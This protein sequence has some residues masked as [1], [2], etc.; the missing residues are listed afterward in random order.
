MAEDW[1]FALHFQQ[2]AVAAIKDGWDVH[3]VCNVGQ[4]GDE[5]LS[6]IV[7]AGIHVIPVKLARTGITP[8]LDLK[9]FF[10]VY[11]LARALKPKIIHAVALKPILIS[12]CISSLAKIPLLAM[13]T[14]LG[15]VFTGESVKAALARPIVTTA[16]RFVTKNPLSKFV[17]LN[18]EDAAWIH[19]NFG[20]D[21]DKIITIPGTGIDLKRFSPAQQPLAAPFKIA[22]VG[23]MLKDKGIFEL[24]EAVKILRVKQIKLQLI[25]AG[26]PDPSNPAS[27]TE[28]QLQAW[29]QDGWCSCSGHIHEI[30][31]LYRQVHAVTLPSYREGLGMTILEAAATGLPCVATDVPGCRSAVVDGET[32]IL[33]PPR[34]PQ[35]LADAIERLALQP[36]LRQSMGA[37]ARNLV[38][39]KFARDI[40]VEQMLDLYRESLK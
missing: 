37:K 40:V 16:M 38:E 2:F 11:D 32:G 8:F 21:N 12:Q 22:Y 33:V 34:D 19:E 5:I 13:I 28:A 7:T 26:A 17:V 6:K 35:A 9:A 23:R 3:L 1:Y 15:Y 27:I 39:Q 31:N 4:K 24:I 36:D 29:Q 30:E 10:T 20:A 14:G 18:H 25:L